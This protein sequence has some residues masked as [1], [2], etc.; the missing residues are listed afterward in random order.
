VVPGWKGSPL[1]KAATRSGTA[2][3]YGCCAMAIGCRRRARAPALKTTRRRRQ[4]LEPED[5][6]FPRGKEEDFNV[7][8]RACANRLAHETGT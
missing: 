2:T 3:D 4:D 1:G 5:F 8:T 7:A 6:D